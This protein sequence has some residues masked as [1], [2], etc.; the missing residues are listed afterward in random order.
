MEGPFD[1]RVVVDIAG[2]PYGQAELRFKE[3]T[4]PKTETMMCWLGTPLGDFMHTSRPD[5]SDS[6]R[7][8]P[9]HRHF[10]NGLETCPED[11]SVR[12]AQVFVNARE[13]IDPNDVTAL[14]ALEQQFLATPI[15][16][17]WTHYFQ[18]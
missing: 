5:G 6:F 3:M 8:R 13:A 1:H 16:T 9:A 14:H 12:A 17:L 18:V 2:V 10:E 11:E 4:D 15:G 7:I